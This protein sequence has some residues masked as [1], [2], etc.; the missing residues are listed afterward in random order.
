M[1]KWIALLT[2]TCLCVLSGCTE[3]E[4]PRSPVETTAAF[5]NGIQNQS[6]DAVKASSDW[7]DFNIKAFTMEDSDYMDSVDKELQKQAYE[8]MTHFEHTEGKETIQGDQAS[9]T[10]EIKQYDFSNSLKAG[11]EQAE[12]KVQELSKKDV[13]DAE[14]EAAIATVLFES[15]QKTDTMKTTEVQ[16]Q[17]K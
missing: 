7:E 2:L 12:K 4:T 15:L 8:K 9:V 14:T 5:L 16:I 1:K 11:M 6:S 10:V 13:S 17:L 3:K